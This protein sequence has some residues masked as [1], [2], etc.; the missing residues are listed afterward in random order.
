MYQ[1]AWGGRP[2]RGTEA[3]AERR[4]L[5]VCARATVVVELARLHQRFFESQCPRR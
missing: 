1:E 5:D 4:I 3:V 2:M